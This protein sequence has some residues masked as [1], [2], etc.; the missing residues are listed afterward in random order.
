MYSAL[1]VEK[2]V[3]SH[4]RVRKLVSRFAGVPIVEIER[5]GEIFNRRHQNF[6]LQ[7]K[8]PALILAEKHGTRVLP[9]P[10]GY[11]FSESNS[12]YFSHMYNCVYDCR[13]CFLQ[14][15]YRSANYVLFVN[16]EDFAED[17]ERVI[18]ESPRDS[19]F[20]S[21]YD[22]DSLAMEPTS[23]FAGYF[24]E[25]F[26]KW[27][28]ATLELRTKSTQVRSLLNR[29]AIPNCIVAM[30]FTTESA[31]MRWENGVPTLG[32][33]LQALSRLQAAGWKVALRF[34]PIIPSPGVV[35]ECEA[36]FERVFEVV[37]SAS[38]HSASLG[39][40]RMPKGYYKRTA[41]LYPD[42]PLYA[43]DTIVRDGMVEIDPG[44]DAASLLSRLENTL[45]RWVSGEQYYRCEDAQ[46]SDTN[47]E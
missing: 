39:K 10:A 18:A 32:K 1:Y 7:K 6:R 47:G 43:R 2:E 44:E 15:M 41:R 11:G 9:A 33:R 12:Y 30:S 21:G 37:D 27:P 5:F 24:L 4:E 25:Q 34:E 36:L 38:L 42:D 35:N 8:A 31:G 16:Y 40:F 46:V 26:A 20:Y 19:V 45:L 17:I 23:Q 29:Q 3:R 28:Q 13:Y 14:G 22:C